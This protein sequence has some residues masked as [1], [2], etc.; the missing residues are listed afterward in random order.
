MM[1]YVENKNDD[2]AFFKGIECRFWKVEENLYRLQTSFKEGLLGIGFKEYEI[3]KQ[4]SFYQIK[5]S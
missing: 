2:Y 1:C 5:F 4:M 3:A